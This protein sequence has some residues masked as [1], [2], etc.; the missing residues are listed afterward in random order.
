MINLLSFV[1]SWKCKTSIYTSDGDSKIYEIAI[2]FLVG[3]EVYKEEC[4]VPLD[5]TINLFQFEN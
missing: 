5:A 1:F 2:W 4:E 3:V